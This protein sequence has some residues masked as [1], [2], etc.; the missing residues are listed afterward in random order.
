M[1]GRVY[2]FIISVSCEQQKHSGSKLLGNRKSNRLFSLYINKSQI[3]NAR[4][5][6][7]RKEKGGR[8]ANVV[9][10][11]FIFIILIKYI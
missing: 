9:N 8:L 5:K 10:L 11:E 4:E 1:G 7:S 6:V 3:K 2:F